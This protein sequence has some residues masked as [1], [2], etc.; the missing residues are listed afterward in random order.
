[1]EL[2]IR[3]YTDR[4][5]KGRHGQRVSGVD[6]IGLDWIAGYQTHTF[7]CKYCEL[8][9]GRK[10][11]ERFFS[12]RAPYTNI[13]LRTPYTNVLLRVLYTNVLLRVPYTNVFLRVP[14]TN[15]LLRAPYTEV[16]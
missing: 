13:V 14:Y 1:M 16:V 8:L 11:F 12:L 9:H 6:W 3:K 7:V 4:A 5:L 15:V 2:N 10:Q